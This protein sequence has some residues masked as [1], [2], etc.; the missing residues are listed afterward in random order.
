MLRAVAL[1]L[2]AG[3]VFANQFLQAGA[4]SKQTDGDAATRCA[5]QFRNFG[6]TAVVRISENQDLGRLRI[7]IRYGLVQPLIDFFREFGI[8]GWRRSLD[9]FGVAGGRM[10]L[11]RSDDIERLIEGSPVQI[12]L[13]VFPEVRWKSTSNKSQEKRLKHIFGIFGR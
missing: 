12:A 5:Q 8:R 13:R 1:A 11:P 9:A 6:V 10:P 3:L 2:R 7:E 4:R